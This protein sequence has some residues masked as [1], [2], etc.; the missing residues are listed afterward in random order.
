[1]HTL[2]NQIKTIIFAKDWQAMG[3]QPGGKLYKKDF[4]NAVYEKRTGRLPPISPN[5]QKEDV[6][7]FKAFKSNLRITI[8]SRNYLLDLY[9]KVC[10]KFV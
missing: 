5:S 1:M 3:R 7:S 2:V 8:R 4:A 9:Q 6:Q 10:V